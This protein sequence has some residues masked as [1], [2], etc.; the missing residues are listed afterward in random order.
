MPQSSLRSN[1]MTGRSPNGICSRSIECRRVRIGWFHWRTRLGWPRCGATPRPRA[2][3]PPPQNDSSTP[4]DSPCT[5]R[6]FSVR[7]S[8]QQGTQRVRT[9]GSPPSRRVATFTSNSICTGN[10]PSLGCETRDIAVFSRHRPG[11][12]RCACAGVPHNV[13]YVRRRSVI[14]RPILCRCSRHEVRSACR[15]TNAEAVKGAIDDARF[16]SIFIFS[17]AA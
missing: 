4:R 1:R 7:P 3:S 15:L 8:R 14:V 17:F 5:R 12:E 13:S 16:A 11:M 9:V 6:Y 10:L 2:G